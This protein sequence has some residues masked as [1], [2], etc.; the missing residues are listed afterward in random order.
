MALD[1]N[2][3]YP[4]GTAA[5]T[6]DYPEG[7]AINETVLDA[8]DGFPWEKEGINDKLGFQQALLRVTGQAASG[9][10]DTALASQYLQGVIELASGRATAYDDGGVADA[11]V[12]DLRTGQQYA[13]GLFIGLAVRFT[14]VNGNIGAAT[15]DYN[16]TIDAIVNRTGGGLVLGEL[17]AGI[18][19]TAVFDGTDWRLMVGAEV[20]LLTDLFVHEMAADADYTLTADENRS[21]R[22][23]IT[24]TVVTLTGAV[25]IFV[26]PIQR[27]FFAKNATAQTLT[28]RAATGTGVD[29]PAGMSAQLMYSGVN[30]IEPTTIPARV[31]TLETKI[32][33]L[34]TKVID[35]GDWDMDANNSVSVAHGL[36]LSKIRSVSVLIRQDLD[37]AFYD[38]YHSGGTVGT[39]TSGITVDSTNITINRTLSGFFDSTGFNATS[40]NRGWIT[41]IST[42]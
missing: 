38:I 16:G 15:L 6:A 14:P 8:L 4:I 30:V 40:F 34:N 18:E 33:G 22:I 23:V 41:V 31:D 24:D 1:Q 39:G 37:V 9:S 25:T 28:F 27:T 32:A 2:A 11:Y 35:I 13:A 20:D 7:S 29:V 19:A 42:D 5:P 10:A 21:G 17:V 3:Q 12:M 26:A 36:T